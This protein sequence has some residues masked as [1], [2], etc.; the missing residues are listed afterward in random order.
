[1]RSSIAVCAAVP[2]PAGID[3][4][5][6]LRDDPGRWLPHPRPQGL[7]RWRFELEALGIVR[8]VLCDVSDAAVTRSGPTRRLTW[9]P[10]TVDADIVAGDRFLPGFAG[11]L[12]VVGA[13]A[14]PSV[15]LAGDVLLPLGRLG[16]ALDQVALR[17]VADRSL[18]DLL[19]RIAANLVELA[20]LSAEERAT[21]AGSRSGRPAPARNHRRDARHGR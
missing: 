4:E 10:V 6:A 14:T 15:V 9:E 1:M 17:G 21:R 16:V 19:R 8:P 11:E 2:L 13:P 18:D 5:G 12:R 20:S 3:A 7:R